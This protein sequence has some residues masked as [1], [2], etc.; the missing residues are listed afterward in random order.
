MPCFDVRVDHAVAYSGSFP[1]PDQ[2]VVHREPGGTDRGAVAHQGLPFPL[3]ESFLAKQQRT[4]PGYSPESGHE[5]VDWVKERLLM[6]F[7]EWSSLL[8]AMVRDHGTAARELMLQVTGRIAV[9]GVPGAASPLI[10]AVEMLPEIARGLQR[11]PGEIGVSPLLDDEVSTQALQRSLQK[12]SL[13][14]GGGYGGTG[15]DREDPSSVKLLGTF[16]CY[17]GPVELS[18]LK[19]TLALPDETLREAVH[20]LEESG[21]ALL[22]QFTEESLAPEICDAA[23]LESLLRMLRRSRRPSFEAL[24]LAAL[25]LF[26]ASFQGLTKRGDSIDD[27]RARLDQLL[28]LPLWASAWEEEVLP[29]RIEPYFTAWLDSLMQ[30]SDL[31]WFGCGP[32][33]LSFAFPEELELFQEGKVRE[34]E[35]DAELVARLIP[36][37]NGRYS[38]PAI[39]LSSGLP[40]ASV[41]AE[42]WKL[43]FKGEFSNDSFASV[44]K[45]ILNRFVRHQA[46]QG[47]THRS[48]RHIPARRWHR[49]QESTGNWYLLPREK[50]VPDPLAREEMNKDRVRVLLDRYGILFRELLLRELPALQWRR[51]FRTLRI[52]ELSGELLSG[53]FFDGIAGLQF[54][55]PEAYRQLAAGLPRDAVYWVNAADPA[56]LCGTGLEGLPDR[57]PA[58][59]PSTHLV[60]H[61]VHLVLVFKRY[62]EDL[63]IQAPPDDPQF[64]EYLSFFRVLLAREFNPAKR[65]FVERING[66]P[67]AKSAYAETL[68]A[69]GFQES[70]KGLELWRRY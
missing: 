16:L 60:Y 6:P 49:E 33:R 46:E 44:R 13:R 63:E 51:L 27:L 25:P 5:L 11:E 21:L 28:G 32:R 29:A 39:S 45:G 14:S 1:S 64:P 50:P 61:G 7:E 35:T 9:L 26:L 2:E 38:L 56:S 15:A 10:G 34:S 12:M 30:T 41:T 20:A 23:N 53:N 43:A 31:L 57:L 67:A 47:T 4:A 22:D 62:G 37:P 70:Y 3:I 19:R 54:M 8:A 48:L 18:W 42:L 65:I 69:F 55:S 66:G 24:E 52:M 36:D 40:V 58:R 68:K 17:Y 59:L